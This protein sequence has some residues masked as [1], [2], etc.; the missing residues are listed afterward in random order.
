MK[1]IVIIGGGFAGVRAAQKLARFGRLC[2]ITLISEYQH[3]EYYPA[4]FRIMRGAP[5]Q[6]A[7]LP[8]PEIFSTDKVSLLFDTVVSVDPHTKTVVT[9][10]GTTLN[11]D[12]I[13]V[14]MGSQATYFNI[15][16]AEQT[17]MPLR[18]AADVVALMEH[19]EHMFK[20]HAHAPT[21][22][23]IVAF[24]FVVVGGGPSG[25]ELA[26]ELVDYT[27]HLAR[28][29]SLDHSLVTIDLIES[30]N[31]L[32]GMLPESVSHY[33]L[34]RLR[35]MG[36]LV[37]L[38]RTVIKNDS[39]TLELSDS[40]LGARTVV[41]TAGVEV[42][43]TA[44]D[45]PG[46]TYGARGKIVVDQFMQAKGFEGVYIAGD[47][48]DV[49]YSGLAQTALHH[50]DSIARNCVRVMRQRPRAAIT[51]RQ[52]AFAIPLGTGYGVFGKGNFVIRGYLAWVMR[53]IIDLLYISSVVSV[54]WTWNN[55]IVPT[56]FAS[57]VAN[58]NGVE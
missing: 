19:V 2:K 5:R 22:E 39:W 6:F 31:R 54:S 11:A 26:V 10:N 3:L 56:V 38:N 57:K 8:L 52:N 35:S 43:S 17:T 16:G 14:A 44:S 47:I 51:H 58:R 7:E 13:I 24:R 50:A 55:I 29:Y 45:I 12:M 30:K 42:R 40:H 32:L 49:P 34:A 21:D 27:K 25:V 15:P 9:Q 18:R 36:V 23:Q 46:F 20:S 1:H 53:S 33:A 48:A 28:Q 37:H 41:W 4:V